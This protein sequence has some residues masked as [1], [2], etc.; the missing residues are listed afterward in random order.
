M[1]ARL[2]SAVIALV[3]LAG[4]TTTAG[5]NINYARPPE[6]SGLRIPYN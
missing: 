6:P 5:D 2:L 3:A 4:C 1:P